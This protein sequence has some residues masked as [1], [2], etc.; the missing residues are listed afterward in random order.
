MPGEKKRPSDL[1]D[2]NARTDAEMVVQ[3]NT[4]EN[5]IKKLD[6]QIQLN[7][8]HI[9]RLRREEQA[10]ASS[11]GKSHADLIQDLIAQNEGLWLQKMN[12]HRLKDGLEW[13]DGWEPGSDGDGDD[14]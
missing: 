10:G 12:W 1:R 4:I 9:V 5:N 8:T 11:E 13:E 6:D 3:E 2:V 7:S 14:L